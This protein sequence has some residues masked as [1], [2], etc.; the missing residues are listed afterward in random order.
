MWR[1]DITVV[2]AVGIVIFQVILLSLSREKNTLE[3]KHNKKSIEIA[4]ILPLSGKSAQLGA[5]IY[6]GIELAVREYKNKFAEKGLEIKEIVKD[7]EDN[8]Q[9]AF[10][11]T[12][13]IINE[14]IKFVIG[15][16]G[17]AEAMSMLKASEADKLLILSPTASFFGLS[18]DDYFFRIFLSD[19][20]FAKR[21]AEKA[22]KEL[23]WR[24]MVCVYKGE[25]ST[26]YF[27]NVFSEEF[28]RLGGKIKSSIDFKEEKESLEKIVSKLKE[29]ASFDAILLLFEK[30]TPFVV[31]LI[32][33]LRKAGFHVPIYT[34]DIFENEKL[35]EEL[36]T[37][38][39]GIIYTFRSEY[40]ENTLVYDSTIVREFIEKYKKQYYSIP[41]LYSALGFDAASILCK[42]LLGTLYDLSVD[43]VKERLLKLEYDGVTGHIM[44][45]ENGDVNSSVVLKTVYKGKFVKY[46]K[47][48]NYMHF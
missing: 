13:E 10:Y 18:K 8:P 17:S 1:R 5:Q 38:A 42:V 29:V 48:S 35:L 41:T 27:L 43:N 45:D 30:I 15:G 2:I 7:S 9:K 34:T 47:L 46:N 6:K 25:P 11:L 44:F 33:E 32:R 24:D 26:Q 28:E 37:D 40:S 14:G 20:L 19:S 12:Q 4:I 39:E 21:Q 36:S 31:D 3:G 16:V 22:F 23:G